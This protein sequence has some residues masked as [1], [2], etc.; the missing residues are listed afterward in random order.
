MSEEFTV[1][2]TVLPAAAILKSATVTPAKMLNHEGKLGV[3]AKDAYA[4]LVILE[5][6]PL[7]DITTLDRPED[8]LIAVIKAGRLQTGTLTGFPK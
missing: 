1:R 4:D 7:E 6:N 8:N 2:A 3:I 5:S